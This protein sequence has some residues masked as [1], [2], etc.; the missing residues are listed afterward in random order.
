MSVVVQAGFRLLDPTAWKEDSVSARY[1]QS[2]VG[3]YRKGLKAPLSSY[4][5]SE[6]F[7]ETVVQNLV[8][9]RWYGCLRV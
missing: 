8:H 9:M 2:L 3:I 1:I 7:V 4:Q 5:L 6:I